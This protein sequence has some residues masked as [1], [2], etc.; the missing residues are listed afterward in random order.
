MTPHPFSTYLSVQHEKTA[1][2]RSAMSDLA[3]ALVSSGGFRAVDRPV[4]GLLLG[5]RKAIPR[6]VRRPVGN[7]IDYLNHP[8]FMVALPAISFGLSLRRG[9]ST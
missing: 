6:E 2:V 7:V 8:A 4:R 1:G 3:E 9:S 5:A